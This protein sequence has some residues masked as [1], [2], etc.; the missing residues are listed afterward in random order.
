[1]PQ[2]AQKPKF[3]PINNIPPERRW[4]AGR[5][6]GYVHRQQK[7]LKDALMLAA[8]VA[9]DQLEKE[10]GLVGYLAHQAI[11]EPVAFMGLLGKVL[12]MQIQGAA[13]DGALEIRWLPPE[14]PKVV[15]ID[16]DAEDVS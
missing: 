12:P 15:T 10:S 8:E 13:S 14:E 9:G 4:K 6:V 7:I 2:T 16:G 3:N 1:M 5:P 11:K